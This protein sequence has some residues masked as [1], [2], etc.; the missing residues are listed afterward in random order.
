MKCDSLYN[1]LVMSVTGEE[2]DHLAQIGDVA[3]SVLSSGNSPLNSIP[4]ISTII[5]IYKIGT[6]LAER[7]HLKNIYSFIERINNKTID[8]DERE[9]YIMRL[10]SKGEDERNKELEFVVLITSRY[11]SQDKS[12]M[13]ADLY[14]AYINQEIDYSEF[15]SYAEILDRFLPGD[16]NTLLKGSQTSIDDSTVSDSML[17]LTSLGLFAAHSQDITANNTLGTIIIPANSEKDYLLTVFGSKMKNCLNSY[18]VI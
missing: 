2:S 14:Y 7:H 15:T 12:Q 9:Q 17:R 13:L 6:T 1:A 11:L 5:A 4:F 18:S 3:L 10:K 16:I 8:A